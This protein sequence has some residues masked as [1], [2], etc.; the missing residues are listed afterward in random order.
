MVAI[1]VIGC[2]YNYPFVRLV[3]H[4]GSFRSFVAL[5][6]ESGRLARDSQLGINRVIFSTKSKVEVMHIDSSF[7]KPNAWIMDTKIY[8]RHNL[9]LAIDGQSQWCSLIPA[10]QPCDNCL[11]QSQVVSLQPPLP[12]PMLKGGQ[13][14]SPLS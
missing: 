10:A 4:R 14:C 3:I 1:K 7:A 8:R 6:Q 11:Q 5:H 12:L 9:H 13:Q 2:G